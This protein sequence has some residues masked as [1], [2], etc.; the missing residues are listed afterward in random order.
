MC[1]RPCSAVDNHTGRK[2]TRMAAKKG[3]IIQPVA[4]PAPATAP[5]K[6]AG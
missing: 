1:L 5:A 6:K 4:K 2:E 3:I